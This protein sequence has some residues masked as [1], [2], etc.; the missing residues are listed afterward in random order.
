MTSYT[1]A[2][3]Y[4]DQVLTVNISETSARCPNCGR[5]TMLACWRKLR[6][7]VEGARWAVWGECSECGETVGCGSSPSMSSME[8]ETRVIEVASSKRREA[9]A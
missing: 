2:R 3:E 1:E 7:G 4:G 9:R 5:P 8:A 6:N